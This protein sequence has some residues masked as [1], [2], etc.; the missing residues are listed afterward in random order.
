[1]LKWNDI[2]TVYIMYIES[3]ILISGLK[4]EGIL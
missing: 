4:R 2:Y 3:G 1:M